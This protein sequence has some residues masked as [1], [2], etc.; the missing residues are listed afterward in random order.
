M[1]SSKGTYTFVFVVVAWICSVP[2]IVVIQLI[3]PAHRGKSRSGGRQ[4]SLH[5][6]LITCTS[7][8]ALSREEVTSDCEVG[9]FLGWAFFG[10]WG[11]FWVGHFLG[12]GLVP[13]LN[14]GHFFHGFWTIPFSLWGIFIKTPQYPRGW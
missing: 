10:L 2:A 14:P 9:H 6:S 8:S 12:Q 7:M 11:I 3:L 13:V 4:Q 5:C 1:H